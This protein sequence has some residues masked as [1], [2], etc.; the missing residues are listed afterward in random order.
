MK[1]LVLVVLFV[2]SMNGKADS[3]PETCAPG[4]DAKIL[5]EQLNYTTLITDTGQYSEIQIRAPKMYK[6]EN[7]GFATVTYGG[8]Y[9]SQSNSLETPQMIVSLPKTSF[10]KLTFSMYLK[11]HENSEQVVVTLPYGCEGEAV[12]LV[13]GK[14]SHVLSPKQA[15]PINHMIETLSLKAIS[16]LEIE[17]RTFPQLIVKSPSTSATISLNAGGQDWNLIAHAGDPFMIANATTNV[18]GLRIAPNGNVHI[19]HLLTPKTL[20][21]E[22]LM[23]APSSPLMGTIYMDY[24]TRRLRAFDGKH[25]YDLW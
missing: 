23:S 5:Q 1:S 8:S 10:N 12:M 15:E 16:K 19:D 25:W 18:Q 21:L 13:R 14:K 3:P 17:N 6:G 22:P 9:I 24:K 2:L 20:R 11:L 4:P 7:L